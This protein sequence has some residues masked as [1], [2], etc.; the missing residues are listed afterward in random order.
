MPILLSVDH[1]ERAAYAV[2]TG[3][4][5]VADV[6][7]HLNEEE[8]NGGL[9]YRELIEASQ[10]TAALESHDV[11][12]IADL[13]RRLGQKKSLGPTAIIVSDDLSYGTL[14]ML[15]TY[16]GGVC[17]LRPFRLTER[18]ESEQWLEFAPIAPARA[19]DVESPRD[20]R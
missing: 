17:E 18:G 9:G 19:L 8:A 3:T 7:A 10:A 6:Q 1:A 2:A 16:L 20:A 14:R 12:R 5:T 11:R 4:I 15:G 13:L